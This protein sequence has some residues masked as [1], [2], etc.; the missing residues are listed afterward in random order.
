MFSVD[1]PTEFQK[2][3]LRDIMS[4]LFLKRLWDVI[5]ALVLILVL[6]PVWL[7]IIFLLLIYNQG[8]IFFFQ[9]R[10]GLHGKGFKI[11]KF[12]TMSTAKDF[13]GRLLDDAKRI[14][15]FGHWLRNNSLDELPQ[16]YN[17][18]SGH[19][20][21]VGPRPLLL[22]YLPRYNSYQQRRHEVKPGLTGWAQI[23]GRNG[24][25]WDQKFSLDIWYVDH[26]SFFLDLKILYQTFFCVFV[27]KG[28]SQNG[29]ASMEPFKDLRHTY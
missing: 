1:V 2:N 3:L 18:L 15:P 19:M 4:Y 28:I 23:N 8:D 11:I 13:H 20:S 7:L 16:L 14:T 6:S 12:K 25:S 29:H 22:E 10:A 17:V 5:F 27:R 21:L 26:K 24:I 9:N